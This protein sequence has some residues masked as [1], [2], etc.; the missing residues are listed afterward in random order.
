MVI[1]NFSLGEIGDILSIFLFFQYR[2]CTKWS[3][4][5]VVR[6]ILRNLGTNCENK[7]KILNLLFISIEVINEHYF[8]FGIF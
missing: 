1:Y 7:W 6:R 8:L 5:S 3:T 2:P 4:N